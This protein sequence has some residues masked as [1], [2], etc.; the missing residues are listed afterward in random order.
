MWSALLVGLLAMTLA[1]IPTSTGR[2]APGPPEAEGDS[3]SD[4]KFLTGSDEDDNILGKPE[5]GVEYTG[6]PSWDTTA[7]DFYNSLGRGGWTRRFAYGGYWAWE[8]DL[9]VYWRGGKEH[10]YID[11][12]DF[13]LFHGH[14]GGSYDSV[15]RRHLKG[16]WFGHNHR[17]DDSFL[18]PGDAYRAWGDKDMEWMAMKGCQILNN[19]SRPYWYGAMDRLHLIFGFKT[20]SYSTRWGRFGDKFARYVRWGYKLH[21]AW[22][23][24]TDATQPH[25]RVIARVIAEDRC[26]YNDRWYRSCGDRYHDGHYWYWDHRAG[27]EPARLVDPTDLD[28]EMP[29]YNVQP[30]YLTT[31]DV[32]ELA[33]AFG[34]GDAP[35][36]LDEEE[37]VYRVT[38]GDLDLTVD[39]QGLYS[40]IN[41]DRLWSVTETMTSS[42][43][44]LDVADAR[45]IA[46]TFLVS[47]SLLPGDAQYYE[48]VPEELGE[49]EVTE[50]P[51]T[52]VTSLG[53]TDS[54]TDVQDT[55]SDTTVTTWQVIYS[56]I[57][58]Y[59]STEGDSVEFSVQGPGAKLKVYVAQDGEVIG[60]MGGWRVL[61]DAATLNT[62]NII[63]PSQ[64]SSLFQELG[65]QVNLAPTL[66]NAET[67]TVTQSTVG[68]YENGSGVDQMSLTPSYIMELEME[69]TVGGILTSTAFVP[70]SPSLMPPLASVTSYTETT[71]LVFVGDT[72]TLTA[73]DASQDLSA[74]GYSGNLDFALG[75]APYT[76]TWRLE[77]TGEVLGAGQS[78]THEVTFGDYANLGRNY[79]VPLSVV[80][81]V[82]D[83][84]GNTST[85]TRT[86]YFAETLDVRK[87]YL[88]AI[89]RQ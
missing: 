76:Y 86:F 68:Y 38:E 17:H 47:N 72:I 1:I 12:V 69:D 54:F 28:Y 39:Q 35:A 51:S 32:S 2:A 48:V 71:P 13:G 50:I 59:T 5:V 65:D 82:T 14:G 18:V 19:A 7:R 55:V 85:S 44:T 80:L 67:V 16:P 63:T 52:T 3:V 49:A 33:E 27:S 21:Q 23:R 53:V 60:A 29:V 31:D 10:R 8:E 88:P 30:S 79:D 62:V 6:I 70:A 64:M 75:Q 36:T 42:V 45:D 40:F 41:L 46:H 89:L 56:R 43:T 84:S 58:T 25:H 81:E 77:N 20:N 74:L 73:A 15:Y 83:A 24:A 57:L 37:Q 11:T 66:Y 87:V 61:E 26:H 9:K 34:L 78:I 4:V 22:F